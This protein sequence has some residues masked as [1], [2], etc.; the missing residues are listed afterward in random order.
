MHFLHESKVLSI[1]PFPPLPSHQI[2]LNLGTSVGD[3]PVVKPLQVGE[4]LIRSYHTPRNGYEEDIET[5]GGCVQKAIDSE[6]NILDLVLERPVRDEAEGQDGEVQ[7]RV[8]VVD[9]G[10]TSHGNEWQVMQ[11]PS[12]DGVETGIM[13]LVEVRLLELIVAALPADEIPCNHEAEN[14]EGCGREPI[15]EWISEKEV[16]DN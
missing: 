12:N 7:C 8:I 4:L 13:D 2:A 1:P 5:D 3:S 10:N 14:A 16:L 15:D 9:I 6:L 11:K